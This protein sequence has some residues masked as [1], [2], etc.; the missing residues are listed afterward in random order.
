MIEPMKE[1]TQEWFA[2]LDR[3][4]DAAALDLFS[5]RIVPLL[6]DRLHERFRS[7]H[8]NRP[9]GGRYQGLISLLGYTP[10]TVILAARF[11]QPR[12]MVVLHTP[13]TAPFL[14]AVRSHSGLSH[15]TLRAIVFDKSS[16]NEL[17]RAFDEGMGGLAGFSD[18]AVEL[19]GGTKP[20]GAVLH[21]A[22]AARGVDT[23][24]IDY[25]QYDPRHRKPIPDST[26][27]RLLETGRQDLPRSDP[28]IART[29]GSI[30][31]SVT[32]AL[33]QVKGEGLSREETCL[34]LEGIV[35]DLDRLEVA[36]D[37]QPP[38]HGHGQQGKRE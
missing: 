28:E 34:L 19:T 24:Y 35:A 7:D 31:S 26:Y 23:L 10:D 5:S 9:H 38:I 4:E 6:L 37:P 27:V 3:K 12:S 29:L 18:V 16:M 8:P 25:A 11:A 21:L 15:D 13:E 20:M 30:R 17:R 22:A 2:L 33:L 1:A 32:H 14:E 36:A